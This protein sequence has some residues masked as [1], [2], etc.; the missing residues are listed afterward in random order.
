[1]SRPLLFKLFNC[2][3]LWGLWGFSGF[4]Q[5]SWRMQEMTELENKLRLID[6]RGPQS[7]LGLGVPKVIWGTPSQL[8][9]TRQKVVLELCCN[10]GSAFLLLI[11]GCS[12]DPKK[13]FETWNL[14]LSFDSVCPKP[15]E[16]IQP[17]P[18]WLDWIVP[19]G[20]PCA[21]TGPDQ[22][23]R[24]ARRKCNCALLSPIWL[25]KPCPMHR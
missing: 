17:L 16:A 8:F 2:C 14:L 6:H 3:L 20:S 25:W 24:L 12:N 4:H 21:V 5:L 13:I 10:F 15:F 7:N 22:Y 1:M 9:W 19:T 11:K 18:I 23:E